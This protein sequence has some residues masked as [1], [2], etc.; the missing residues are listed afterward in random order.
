MD[1]NPFT[2][3]QSNV[4][5]ITSPIGINTNYVY[6]IAV[7]FAIHLA[8]FGNY[9]GLYLQLIQVGTIALIGPLLGMIADIL[10]LFGVVLLCL[11]RPSPYLFLSAGLLSLSACVLIRHLPFSG[12]LVEIT[13]G[14][15]AAIAF[16][17]W[18]VTFRHRR[19]TKSSD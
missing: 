6:A 10:M 17:G 15:G 14:F 19:S 3:P 18:W 5:D 12:P 4:A 7:L 8:I 16:F 1:N 2:P 11:K 9:A 13:Y